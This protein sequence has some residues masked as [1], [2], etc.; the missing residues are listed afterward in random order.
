MLGGLLVC[1]GCQSTGHVPCDGDET[2]SPDA[3][4]DVIGAEFMLGGLLASAGCQ[5]TGHVPRDGDETRSPD[6][7]N[8]VSGAELRPGL[9]MNVQV[10]VTGQKEVD[11]KNRR[12]SESGLITLPY[13]GDVHVAGVTVAEAQAVLRAAYGRFFVDPQVIVEC[14][15]E[16]GDTAVSPWG[17]VTVLGRVKKPGHV[18][19]PPTRELTVSRAIQLAGG[20]DTSAR[21]NAIRVTRTRG[22]GTEHFEVN[23]DRIGARGKSNDDIQLVP[24]DAVYVPEGML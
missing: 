18:N 3:R 10:L 24:G 1:A 9:T 11:E 20:L 15:M 4:N 16:S 2:R 23:L 19:M 7:S 13:V 22:D 12:I 17:H 5:S 14:L 21:S 6:A 8:A